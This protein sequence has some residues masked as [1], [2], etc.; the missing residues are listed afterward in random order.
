MTDYILV[1][2]L[3]MEEVFIHPK[4]TKDK[5]THIIF[6]LE[7]LELHYN[8]VRKFGKFYLYQK[9]ENLSCLDK[10]GF[11]PFDENLNGRILKAVNKR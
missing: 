10:I 3:R 9:Q 1:S 2:H 11:E 7:D 8:D 6:E 4:K 5:H